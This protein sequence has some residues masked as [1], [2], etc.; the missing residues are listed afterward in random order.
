[1]QKKY[2]VVSTV[3]TQNVGNKE[4]NCL[5]IK[6]LKHNMENSKRKFKRRTTCKKA[7]V[8]FSIDAVLFYF[9]YMKK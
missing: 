9:N 4:K 2:T 3:S 1:M 8:F 7:E 5:V 6:M